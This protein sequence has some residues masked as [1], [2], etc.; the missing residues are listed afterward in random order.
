MFSRI[1]SQEDDDGSLLK[2]G[3]LGELGVV[4]SNAE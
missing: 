2:L 4:E 3:Q 1:G